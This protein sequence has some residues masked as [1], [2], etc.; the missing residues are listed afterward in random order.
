MLGHVDGDRVQIC[1]NPARRHAPDAELDVSGLTE[2]PRVAIVH[3]HGGAVGTAQDA[4]VAKG[5]RG[6]GAAGLAPGVPARH[7]RK[8]LMR[9]EN[10]WVAVVQT[11][12]AGT[13]DQSTPRPFL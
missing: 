13:G 5:A 2:L 9:A 1:R 12:R 4:H 3:S 10:P 7:E 11:G 8:A 6:I